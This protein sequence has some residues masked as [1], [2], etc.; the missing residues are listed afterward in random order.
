[1]PRQK[2]YGHA[3][4]VFGSPDPSSYMLGLP[5]TRAKLGNWGVVAVLAGTILALMVLVLESYQF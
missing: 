3:D 5:K 1:M 4:A 2:K